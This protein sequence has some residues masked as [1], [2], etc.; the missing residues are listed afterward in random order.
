MASGAVDYAASYFKYKTPTPIIGAPSH[1]TLKRLKQELRANASSVDTDL[2]GGDHGYLGLVLT[3]EEYLR[4]APNTP[5]VAPEFPCSLLIPANTDMVTA[6]NLREAHK[7][8][9]N[10][11]RECREVE[12]ALL[13]HI[14]AA[15]E[16]KY[17]DSLKNEDTDLVE[18]DIPTVLEYLFSSYGK[19]PT[20]EVKE[21][22]VEVLATPFVPSDPMVTI[23]RPIEQLRTLADIAKIPYTESQIVDFGVQLIKNTR[24]F[25]TALGE[26]NSKP[27]Q[28]KT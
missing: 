12:K 27:A 25:E 4:V 23:Y 24:D 26:W 15:V 8:D 20:R 11:Y 10:L 28:E 18:D 14:T 3:D 16:S 6:M 21:K 17:I 9:T 7:R 2:G 1:K 19:V 5:F 13:R 22:E